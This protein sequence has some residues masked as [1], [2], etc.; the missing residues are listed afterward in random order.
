VVQIGILGDVAKGLRIFAVVVWVVL[1]LQF[2][3]I[4]QIAFAL[5][6]LVGL[7]ITLSLLAFEYRKNFKEFKCRKC[8]HH[9]KVS[10]LRLA[11]TLKF[12]GKD[13]APTGTAAYHL[14]CPKCGNK[15]WLVPLE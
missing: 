4:N 2:I 12:E 10:Y 13:P 9:F 6:L 1:I 8:N 14:K 3:V 5:L 7:I 15:S 11:F